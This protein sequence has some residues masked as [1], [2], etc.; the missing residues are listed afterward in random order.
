MER[1]RTRCRLQAGRRGKEDGETAERERIRF[2]GMI[3]NE[4]RV[5]VH[6]KDFVGMMNR[7]RFSA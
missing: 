7:M 6:Y 1:M 4:A 5:P 3:M 2:A